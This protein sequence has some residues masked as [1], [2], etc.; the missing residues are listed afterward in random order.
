MTAYIL[1]V[2]DGVDIQR[3]TGKGKHPQLELADV[4][5]TCHITCEGIL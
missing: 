1:V 3:S 5:P 4:A 2:S